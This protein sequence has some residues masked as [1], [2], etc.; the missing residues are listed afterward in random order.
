VE[1]MTT[2]QRHMGLLKG[3]VRY[4]DVVATEFSRYWKA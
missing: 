2:F 3:E 1:G 4:E